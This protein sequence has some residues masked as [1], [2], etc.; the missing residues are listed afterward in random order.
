M[1]YEEALRLQKH[2]DEEVVRCLKCEKEARWWE[3][4]VYGNCFDCYANSH[5]QEEEDKRL[6]YEE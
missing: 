6:T 3:M 4:R 2:L 5:S 1:N